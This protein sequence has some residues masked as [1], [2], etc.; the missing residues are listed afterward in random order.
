MPIVIPAGYT[1]C[2]V[3]MNLA[4][5][6]QVAECT[7]GTNML[8]SGELT[9]VADAWAEHV[10]LLVNNQ[11]KYVEFVAREAAGAIFTKTYNVNGSSTTDPNPP[12]VSILVRKNT[13]IPG[14]PNKGRLYI[15]SP[16]D[17]KVDAIG[18][19]DTTFVS[20]AQGIMDGFLAAVEAAG[21]TPPGQMVI[22]HSNAGLPATT[23]TG[24]SVQPMVATQ[25]RRLRG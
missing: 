2:N 14:R 16:P 17:N 4:G 10:M 7:F 15:P 24:L 9:D 3:K 12:N 13:V 20:D 11:W 6:A 18:N 22:L 21:T 8:T 5:S 1:Q 23:V 25:R 19:L